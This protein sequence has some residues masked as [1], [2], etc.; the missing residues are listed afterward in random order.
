MNILSPLTYD[1]HRTVFRM[2][3][4]AMDTNLTSVLG[5][6]P[7]SFARISYRGGYTRDM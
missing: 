4:I 3:S 6:P 2:K 7:G 5:S 1:V